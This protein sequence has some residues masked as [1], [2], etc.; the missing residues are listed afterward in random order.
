MSD[1]NI[2]VM[3]TKAEMTFLK[4]QEFTFF[5][6]CGKRYLIRYDAETDLYKVYKILNEDTKAE[7]MKFAFMCQAPITL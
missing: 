1:F 5:Y 7:T 2:C 6:N 4:L 3:L